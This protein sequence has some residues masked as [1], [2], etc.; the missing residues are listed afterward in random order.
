[1]DRTEA[2]AR[3][4]WLASAGLISDG[5]HRLIVLDEITYP[6]NWGWV[7]TGE[8]VRTIRSRP[9]DVSIIATGRDAPA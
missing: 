4:A 2:I 5:K 6:M 7:D 8:V 3:E 9:A 1:M